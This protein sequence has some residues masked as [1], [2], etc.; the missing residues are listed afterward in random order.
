MAHIPDR[1][2]EVLLGA[3]SMTIFQ[4]AD[5]E[6]TVVREVEIR[7]VDSQQELAI[8]LIKG[9]EE[10]DDHDRCFTPNHGLRAERG[11]STLKLHICFECSWI[12]AW[13]N[14]EHLDFSTTRLAEPIFDRYFPQFRATREAWEH[15]SEVRRHVSSYQLPIENELRRSRALIAECEAFLGSQDDLEGKKQ[16]LQALQSNQKTLDERVNLPDNR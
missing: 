8:V 16:M 7:G 12:W 4:I 6:K 3:D 1:W 5:D 13:G 15:V 10:A 14:G 9:I 2:R 11:G